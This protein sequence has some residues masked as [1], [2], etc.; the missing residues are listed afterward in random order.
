MQYSPPNDFAGPCHLSRPKCPYEENAPCFSVVLV[1]ERV[2]M[3]SLPMVTHFRATERHLPYVITPDAGDR[4]Q[5]Q[6][7]SDMPS[8]RNE[9]L[10]GP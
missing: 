1:V 4:A 8:Q 6:R 10:S 3:T 2:R 9:R 7:Q 5:P